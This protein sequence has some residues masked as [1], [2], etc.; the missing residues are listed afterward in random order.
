MNS[1]WQRHPGLVWSNPDAG[2]STRIRAALLRPT[3]GRL[4]DIASEFGIERVRHEWSELQAD[5]S[6]EVRRARPAVGRILGNIEKGFSR[7]A[8]RD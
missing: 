1:F 5:D 3:F 6:R 2:D 8:T 4:L 7:A